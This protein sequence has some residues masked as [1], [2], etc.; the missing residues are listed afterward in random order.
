[1]PGSKRRVTVEIIRSGQP[2]AYADTE[3]LARLTFEKQPQYGPGSKDPD[4]PF[5]PRTYKQQPMIDMMIRET[6]KPA[7]KALVGNFYEE[8]DIDPR[9]DWASPMLKRLIEVEPGVWE[10][11]IVSAYTD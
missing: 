7:I 1:M 3:T 8:T 10:V 6:V 5:E 2:R 11:L 9:P 4:A